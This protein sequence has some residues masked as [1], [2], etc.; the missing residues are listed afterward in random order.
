MKSFAKIIVALIIFAALTG[1]ESSPI[2]KKPL[3][4]GVI[5]GIVSDE[6]LFVDGDNVEIPDPDNPKKIE[7]FIAVQAF[8]GQA[9]SIQVLEEGGL[10]PGK[11]IVELT[12]SI[13]TGD[14]ISF[15]YSPDRDHFTTK[16]ARVGLLSNSQ[17]CNVPSNLISIVE[18]K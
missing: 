17:P 16:T 15:T 14:E 5:T 10:G 12:Y 6:C 18:K 3:K 2:I 1:C 11:S 8:D 7:Y 4:S 9:Y 13:D